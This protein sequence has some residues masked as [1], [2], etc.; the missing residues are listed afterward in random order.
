MQ[1]FDIRLTGVGKNIWFQVNEKYLVSIGK[2]D[3]CTCM[4]GTF[5]AGRG[6][7]ASCKHVAECKKLLKTINRFQGV[8][9]NG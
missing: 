4:H 8:E 7:S 9:L 6:V 5:Q 1:K 2:L 3:A